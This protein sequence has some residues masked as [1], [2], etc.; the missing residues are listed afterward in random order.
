MV[1]FKSRLTGIA[2]AIL[3]AC[4]SWAPPADAVVDTKGTPPIRAWLPSGSPKMVILCLHGLGLHAGSY[5]AFGER[6]SK[7]GVAVYAIDERGFGQFYHRGEDKI[8]F[9]ATMKDI[10][11]VREL[12]AREHPG[13]PLF[14]MGESM[15]GAMALQAASHYQDKFTG[16][17]CSVPAGDR[18]GDLNVDLKLGLKVLT[19]GFT[20]RFNAGDAVIKHSTM[21]HGDTSGVID[22]KSAAHRKMWS[23]DPLGRKD[24]SIGELLVFSKFCDRNTSAARALKEMPVL[25]VQGAKDSLIRPSG[26]WDV[27]DY[28]QTP[29]KDKVLSAQSEHLI[30][31]NGQFGEDDLKY[32]NNWIS[33]V[34]APKVA[35]VVTPVQVDASANAPSVIKSASNLTYWIELKRDGKTFRCNNKTQFKSGDEIRF[36]VRAGVDGYA[37]ILMK[38]GASGGRAVLFPEQ[39]TGT[40][41]AISAGRDCAIPTL[42]YLRFDEHAGVENVSLIF[43]KKPMEIDSVLNDKNT[44]MAY[45]SPDKSGAKDLVPTRMQL[46]WD[47]TNPILIPQAQQDTALASHSSLV[48]VASPDDTVALDIALE[49][50]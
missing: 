3:M 47:D 35:A 7:D 8:D 16:V 36:H 42:T 37:Y 22:E 19:K 41:N 48:H 40:N 39:R 30:F 31:E 12:I 38:Q 15:G 46:S 33:K 9:D 13:V 23:E 27:W 6:M 26:T 17:I 32:V 28:L 11:V 49:H 18:F 34:L 44:V 50:K 14:L 20:G 25:F 2:V 1:N 4:G 10:G 45:V 24:F 43:S 21:K 29:N 5:T